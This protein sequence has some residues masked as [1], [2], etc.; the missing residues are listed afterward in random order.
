MAESAVF[1]NASL[2]TEL[3]LPH[4]RHLFF[5]VTLTKLTKTKRVPGGRFFRASSLS[6]RKR[7]TLRSRTSTIGEETFTHIMKRESLLESLV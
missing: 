4:F 7:G 5:R 1:G 6:G 3:P 2:F